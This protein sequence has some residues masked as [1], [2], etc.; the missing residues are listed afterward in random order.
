M[1]SINEHKWHF[2]DILKFSHG[3][4]GCGPKT[5]FSIDSNANSK[6]GVSGALIE[7]IGSGIG[8]ITILPIFRH[9]FPG[10]LMYYKNNL[11]HKNNLI[12]KYYI[13]YNYSISL[14][15]VYYTYLYTIY[16]YALCKDA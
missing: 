15:N 16:G 14:Y 3:P 10:L 13:S 2:T 12:T 1:P 6:R 4:D 5:T 7:Y 9:H 11:N 8:F